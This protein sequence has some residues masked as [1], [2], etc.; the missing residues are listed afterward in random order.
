METQVIF[1]TDSET[2][3]RASAMAKF[4]GISLN[5]VLNTLFTAYVNG[6]IKVWVVARMNN[7][8]SWLK[9]VDELRKMSQK[10]YFSYVWS[11][12]SEERELLWQ[13]DDAPYITD[14]LLKELA[15]ESRM[16]ESWE[17]ES[18]WPFDNMEDFMKA[19]NSDEELQKKKIVKNNIQ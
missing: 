5:R 18:Y 15:E 6:N 3:Q 7:D 4:D 10:E 19:V 8:F 14:G 16:V 1:R 12:T 17:M 9:P 11:L 13:R 2:K